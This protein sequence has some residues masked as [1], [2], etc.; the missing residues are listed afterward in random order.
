MII[1]IG[2]DLVEIS[3]LEQA[4]ARRGDR[5]RA[6]VFTDGEIRYCE[7]RSGTARFASYAARFAAKEAVMKALGTGW[8]DGIGWRDVEVVCKPSGEPQIQLHKR[9]LERLRELGGS[10]VH[11]SL[12]HSGNI[13][14]AQVVLES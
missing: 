14:A 4:L 5:F 10:R 7:C 12:S 11:L 1:A 8:S 3:R 13:A 6:R 9:A 2:I